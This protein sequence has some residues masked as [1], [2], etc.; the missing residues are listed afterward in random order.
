MADY[1]FYG[2]LMDADVLSAVAGERIPP[3]RLVPARLPGYER[4]SASSGVFPI[5]V[6]VPPVGG[7]KNESAPG[8]LFGRPAPPGAEAGAEGVVVREIGPA[9][10]RRLARYEGPG[11]VAAKRPVTTAEG[12]SEAFVFISL[13][14]GRSSGKA[15]DFDFWRRRYKRRLLRALA[16]EKSA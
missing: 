11:Y 7:Q 9:A 14:P 12:S 1:F 16:A 3:A 10:V 6:A 8:Y 5:I 15:W 4:L 2:S 13:R